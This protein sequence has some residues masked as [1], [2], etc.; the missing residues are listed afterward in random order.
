MLRHPCA[1]HRAAFVGHAVQAI[2]RR[3]APA[4]LT[5]DPEAQ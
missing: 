1:I 3:D 2:D 5:A 4:I